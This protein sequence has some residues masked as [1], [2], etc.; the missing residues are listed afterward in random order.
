V[1]VPNIAFGTEMSQL[2]ILSLTQLTEWHKIMVVNRQQKFQE[3]F[4]FSTVTFS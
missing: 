1:S 4:D 3:E 2:H